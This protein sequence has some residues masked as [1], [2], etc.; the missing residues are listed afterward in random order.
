MAPSC[1]PVNNFAVRDRARGTITA[2]NSS[3]GV[4]RKLDRIR[5]NPRVALAFHTREHSASASSDYVLVQGT[6]TLSRP[7]ADYPSTILDNWERF[8]PWADL[9]PLWKRWRRVYALRVAIEV[10]VERIVVWPD[11]ACS[12]APTVH[13]P[14]LPAEPPTPQAPPKKGSGP[15]LDHVRAA[16]RGQA[17][18]AHAARL[19][20][21][22]WLPGGGPG[23]RGR[24]R[25]ARDRCWTPRRASCRREAGERGSPATGSAAT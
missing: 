9:H 19:G 20:G 17:A 7:I 21:R 24:D 13:G 8:E 6:A 15:R 11:L 25:G 23:R 16:R 2:V 18:P 3:V 12:G 5:R 1:C 22:G 4:W 14:A 10:A